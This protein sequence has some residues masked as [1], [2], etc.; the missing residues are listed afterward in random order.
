MWG[1]NLVDLN[2]C[3]CFELGSIIFNGFN[4]AMKICCEVIGQA[5]EA[6]RIFPRISNGLQ[7]LKAVELLLYLY[8]FAEHKC[9]YIDCI[10]S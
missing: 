6:A 7:I 4:L 9:E 10:I 3:T 8:V 1:F 2:F 5:C